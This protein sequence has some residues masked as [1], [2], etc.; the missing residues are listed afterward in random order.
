MKKF[1][2]AIIGATAIALGTFAAAAPAKAQSLAP[3]TG[4]N[5][6]VNFD[7]DAAGNPLSAGTKISN[8][9]QDYG[10]TISN[11]DPDPNSLDLML[12][13]SN[14]IASGPD[15]NCSGDDGD[16]ATGPSFG[17]AP[18]GNVLIISEDG[19]SSDPDD[20]A[21][22]GTIIFS[23]TEAVSLD[24]LAILDLDEPRQGYIRAFNADG[25]AQEYRM[26]EGTLV[27]PAHPG[28]NSLREYDFSGLDPES[29]TS[30]EVAFP[31]SGAVS[32]LE[33]TGPSEEVP[34][35]L[36][37]LGLVTSGGFLAAARQKRRRKMK[38]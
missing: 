27:N 28:N 32:Y 10:L 9:W 34:E 4:Q 36:T 19:D 37:V 7:T 35:P 3:V 12:F 23:F 16:L 30:L 26:S 18:Q 13:N 33:F 21:G 20:N 1:S 38:S 31:G 24:K 29:I 22:G 11:A 15:K 6:T 14:C 25:L 5:Y 2:T 17:T 8:Q